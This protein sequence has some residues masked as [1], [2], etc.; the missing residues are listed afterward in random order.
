M[1]RGGQGREGKCTFRFSPISDPPVAHAHRRRSQCAR[2]VRVTCP[3]SGDLSVSELGVLRGARS[4][5]WQSEGQALCP[6]RRRKRSEVAS[7]GSVWE[8]AGHLYT[9]DGLILTRTPCGVAWYPPKDMLKS[10]PLLP[11]N[12]T[13][14]GKKLF[15]DVIKM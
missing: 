10:Y 14:F 15:T 5:W 7:R 2:L 12:G 13:L 6:W 3:V 8:L 4:H 11:V 1:S 9:P